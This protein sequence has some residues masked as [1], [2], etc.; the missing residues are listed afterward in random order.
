MNYRRFLIAN[1]LFALGAGMSAPYWVLRINEIV[2]VMYFGIAIGIAIIVQSLSS[3]VVGKYAVER[4]RA[5]TYS[6]ILFSAITLLF[7]LNLSFYMVF[8][9]QIAIGIVTSV[10]IVCSSTLIAEITEK[11][12]LGKRYGYFHSL[13]GI[14]V[15][16]SMIGGGSIALLFGASSIFLISAV[17]TLCSAL[18]LW[19]GLSLTTKCKINLTALRS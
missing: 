4:I 6:Q 13:E 2:G 14:A 5:L 10:Q 17:L 9:I 11:A 3:L 7:S 1:F 19:F 15:G 18:M 12:N 8:I 16:I